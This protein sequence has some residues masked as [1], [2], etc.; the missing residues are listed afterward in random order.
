MPS[1]IIWDMASSIQ[2][3]IVYT[4]DSGIA[5]IGIPFKVLSNEEASVKEVNDHL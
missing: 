2:V 1:M 4:T 3:S 5:E